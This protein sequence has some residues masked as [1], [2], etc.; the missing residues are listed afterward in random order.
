MG[1][2]YPL[3]MRWMLGEYAD[4][5]REQKTR[6]GKRSK[7]LEAVGLGLLA[8]VILLPIFVVAGPPVGTYR[9]VKKIGRGFKRL[10]KRSHKQEEQETSA[11]KT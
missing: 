2:T 9:G 4:E 5:V 10:T 1:V 7:M 3:Q 6:E 11:S 8:T